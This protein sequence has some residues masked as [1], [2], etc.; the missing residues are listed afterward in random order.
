MRS[1]QNLIFGSEIGVFGIL[2]YIFGRNFLPFP[3]GFPAFPVPISMSK[4]I[5]RCLLTPFLLR[6]RYL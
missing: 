6:P 4:H 1:A 5:P 2:G 3:Y